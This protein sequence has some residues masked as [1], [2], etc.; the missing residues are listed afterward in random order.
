MIVWLVMFI[1][2]SAF[3]Y[4]PALNILP[5]T[6]I[7]I[8][9]ISYGAFWIASSAAVGFW[10][11]SVVFTEIIITITNIKLSN[12]ISEILKNS[13]FGLS[14]LLEANKEDIEKIQKEIL[15]NIEQDI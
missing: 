13:E 15:E 3:G 14:V 11:C 7:F 10:N 4:V 12:N 5:D 2:F 8:P 6:S 1:S 9:D